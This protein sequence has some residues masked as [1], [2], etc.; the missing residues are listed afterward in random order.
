[1]GCFHY[2]GY[3]GSV[4]YSDEEQC[5]YGSVLG[6]KR[7]GIYFEGTSVEELKKDFEDGID[8]YL[9]SCLARNVEP[10]KPYSGKLV[11]RLTPDLHGEAAMKAADLGISL[12]EFIRR[13]IQTAVQ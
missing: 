3:S 5:F 1:M 10:E 7:D 13:A 6:L 11:L 4:E 12:N 2:K 8:H 9:A